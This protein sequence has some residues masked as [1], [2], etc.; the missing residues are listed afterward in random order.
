MLEPRGVGHV[1][2]DDSGSF[3]TL[4]IPVRYPLTLALLHGCCGVILAGWYPDHPAGVEPGRLGV[5]SKWN[6]S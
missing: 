5:E 1:Y 4:A 3:V 2:P 6:R